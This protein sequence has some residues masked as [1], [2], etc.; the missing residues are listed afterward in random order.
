[1]RTCLRECVGVRV[2]SRICLRECVRRS[3]FI[4]I[5]IERV[6]MHARIHV[7]M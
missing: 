7:R 3:M 4:L 6:R 1:M 2:R 5:D